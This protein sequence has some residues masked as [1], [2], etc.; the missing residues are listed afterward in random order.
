M[1]S[2]KQKHDQRKRIYHPKGIAPTIETPTGG[3]HIPLIASGQTIT[4]NTPAKSTAK[5]S[6]KIR[7]HSPRKGN[8]K[9]G[10]TGPLESREHSFT[11]DSTPHL[12]MDDGTNPQDSTKETSEQLMLTPYQNTTSSVRDFLAKV[13]ALLGSG[14]ASK[15][16]EAHSSLR[17]A[18]SYGLNDLAIYSLRMSKDFLAT[19]TGIVVIIGAGHR[20]CYSLRQGLRYS[21]WYLLP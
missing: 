6:P 2:K 13:S 16:L 5:G 8:P 14:R 21:F 11:V 7:S 9:K 12:V 10:G 15:I 18:E 3:H 17:Y 19:I 1:G 4:T 20:H